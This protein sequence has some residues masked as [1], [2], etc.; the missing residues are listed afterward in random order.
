MDEVQKSRRRALF[1]LLYLG[2][3]AA[4]TLGIL[5]FLGLL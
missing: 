5:L 2:Y 4:V 3:A 1:Y